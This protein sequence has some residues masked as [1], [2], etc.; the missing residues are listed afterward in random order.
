MGYFSTCR[1]C[2]IWQAGPACLCL[3]RADMRAPVVGQTLP[4]AR[5]LLSPRGA[6]VGPAGQTL[7]LHRAAAD[8]WALINYR[9]SPPFRGNN[10]AG[11]AVVARMQLAGRVRPSQTIKPHAGYPFSPPNS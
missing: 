9:S 1:P 3:T 8:F 2:M 7:F 6:V 11:H 5:H 10:P 4:R